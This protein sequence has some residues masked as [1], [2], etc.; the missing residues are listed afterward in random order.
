MLS[1][2]LWLPPLTLFLLQSTPVPHTTDSTGRIRLTVG[3]D[4][5]RYE[6]IFASCSGEVLDQYDVSYQNVGG[7]AEIWLS[8]SVRVTG[9]GGAMFSQT[10]RPVAEQFATLY[11][12]GYGGALVAAEWRVVG[13]GAGAVL[14]RAEEPEDGN[15]VFPSAYLRLGS[16]EGVHF[17][18]Q[19]FGPP[20][21]AAPPQAFR[22]G[23]GFGQGHV[24]KVTGFVGVHLNAFPWESPE[25]GLTGDV[26]VPYSRSIAIG[27]LGAVYG[28]GYTLGA[29]VRASFGQPPR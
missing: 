13:I 21:A 17:R 9:H 6:E 16:K 29:M 2:R 12:G 22:V 20:G 8:P 14:L 26:L 24:T 3:G 15:Q 1:H 25:G 5:G 7:Q 4:V 23:V 11:E 18:T 19:L 28:G 10:D 27:A